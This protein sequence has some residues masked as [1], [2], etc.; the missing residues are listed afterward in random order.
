MT[1]H[2]CGNSQV[3]ALRGAIEEMKTE[4]LD[5]DTIV[6]PL[7]T[8]DNETQAFSMVENGRVV[9][10]NRR[11]R[12]KLKQYFGFSAFERGQRWGL[13]IGDHHA[14]IFH[15]PTWQTAA[16]S[17]MNLKDMTPI[18]EALFERIFEQ[19]QKHIHAF[20]DQVLEVGVQPFVISAPWPVR[21]DPE[22]TGIHNAPEIMK[23]VDTRARVLFA[24]WLAERGIEIVTP[25][26]EAADQDGMLKPEYTKA[27]DDPY[28]ANFAYGRLMIKKILEHEAKAASP[29]KE[30]KRRA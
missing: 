8:A 23:A 3:R 21:P 10:T 20:I 4:G 17:W 11:F 9:M 19:D 1:L 26:V 14:R 2:I 7:G 15:N 27:S 13:C 16:P 18:S 24:Q 6:F 25:P 30:L 5:T 28:H 22:L 12:N 29:V